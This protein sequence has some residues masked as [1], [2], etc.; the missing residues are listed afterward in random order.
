M[1]S[2]MTALAQT[3]DILRTIRPTP[4]T[5]QNMMVLRY[6]LLAP[7]HMALIILQVGHIIMHVSET[8]HATVP[9]IDTLDGAVLHLHEGELVPLEATIRYRDK[10]HQL[11]H[12]VDVA[13]DQV[14]DGRGDASLLPLAVAETD[15]GVD[16]ILHRYHL[17][18]RGESATTVT[19]YPLVLLTLPL[20]P[21]LA[22]QSLS[23]ATCL[24]VLFPL[25]HVLGDLLVVGLQL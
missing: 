23:A 8:T 6:R 24:A 3:N 17:L 25:A 13:L 11:P 4:R 19:G 10:T 14:P 1:N 7:G 18:T 2:L 5:R 16:D 12:E 9:E 21:A 20:R 15:L 22:T